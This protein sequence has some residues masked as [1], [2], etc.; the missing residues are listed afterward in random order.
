MADN[1]ERQAELVKELTARM[2]KCEVDLNRHKSRITDCYRYALPWRHG[3]EQNDAAVGDTDD[4]FDS[5]LMTTLE[6]FAADMLTTFTPIKSDWVT[7]TPVETMDAGDSN[8]ITEDLT[9]FQRV[10]FAEMARSNLYQALQEAYLDLGPG[11][12]ALCIQD[13]GPSRPIH[14]EAIPVTDLLLER[15]PF[16]SINGRFR[17][18]K[19]V[20]G[21]EIRVLWPS[22]RVPPE[23]Q[24][25]GKTWDVCEGLWRDWADKGDETW[26]YV[27]VANGKVLLEQKLKGRGACPIIVARWS[28]DSTTAWGVGPTYRTMPDFKALNHIKYQELTR[29]D[30][31]VNPVTSYEDDGIMNVEAGLTPGTWIPRAAGSEPPQP[32][33]SKAQLDYAS[34]KSDELLSNIRRAH[35]QDRPE[36]LGRTP[37]SATQWAD[38]A[39]ERARRMGTPATNLVIELQYPIFERFAF[40]LAK[41]GTLPKVTLQG[42]NVALQPISPLLRAQEQEEVVRMDRLAELVGAR[43]GA[44]AVTTILKPVEYANR[45]AERLG[46]D[47]QLVNTPAEMQQAITQFAPILGGGGGGQID[48]AAIAQAVGGAR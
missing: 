46:V 18:R 24:G 22:A 44:E 42:K 6:D 33:E 32:I 3:F 35:Y 41:R 25:K 34:I 23:M 11:T 2:S 8:V 27:V 14:C 28:R 1:T 15:G 17:K 4:I 20:C 40:L 5:S 37:P 19:S 43:F 13:R 21:D 38:Q 36:Q 45:M 29:V 9:K 39:A 31:A 10:V 12:M 26:I 16:G 7:V 48:P 47:P 30:F